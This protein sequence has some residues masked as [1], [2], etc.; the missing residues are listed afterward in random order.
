M[1][2]ETFLAVFYIK[3]FFMRPFWDIIVVIFQLTLISSI[4]LSKVSPFEQKMEER[5][6]KTSTKARKSQPF[7]AES[8]R[9]GRQIEHRSKKKSALS[10]RKWKKRQTN[11]APKQEKVSPFEQKKAEK[12]DKASTGGRKSQPFRAESGRKGW[13]TWH[14][15]VGK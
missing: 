5:A 8:G 7:R 14:P 2:L 11:R 1:P 15:E 12:A 3:K 6:D 4:N 9:K 13:Q 10:S